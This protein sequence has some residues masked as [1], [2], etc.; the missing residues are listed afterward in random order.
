[1][2]LTR[3]LGDW[4]C[5]RATVHSFSLAGGVLFAREV[6][7]VVRVL[8]RRCNTH[9]KS[10]GVVAAMARAQAAAE[11]LSC[12]NATDALEYFFEDLVASLDAQLVANLVARRVDFGDA[13]EAV[14]KELLD[15]AAGK[16]RTKPVAVAAAVPA[17]PTAP[18]RSH[19]AA[20]VERM[21][22]GAAL[23]GAADWQTPP[24][25]SL[26]QQQQAAQ[27]PQLPA[28]PEAAEQI[29]RAARPAP[30]SAP[31]RSTE[32]RGTANGAGVGLTPLRL[33][34]SA[35]IRCEC[36][37]G[38]GAGSGACSGARPRGG[39]KRTRRRCSPTRLRSQWCRATTPTAPLQQL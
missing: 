11:I 15:I 17:T 8:S 39:S 21:P 23:L 25:R 26:Q 29:M 31:P 24:R 19:T 20:T 4:L 3:H 18:T 38:S 1:V 28:T 14:R 10:L 9:A 2:R 12:A 32:A 30:L 37:R 13:A 33:D 5:D 27:Q 16:P 22:M 35:A 7:E 34:F 6:S 36:E